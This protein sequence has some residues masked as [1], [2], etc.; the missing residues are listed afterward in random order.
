MGYHPHYPMD[1]GV[2]SGFSQSHHRLVH[3]L[4]V[5]LHNYDST[6][7][8]IAFAPQNLYTDILQS[9]LIRSTANTDAPFT[10]SDFT[11]FPNEHAMLDHINHPSYLSDPSV[12]RI[13]VAVVFES[14]VAPDITYRIR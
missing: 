9:Y 14:S 7:A 8:S 5:Q 6:H 12:P 10:E 1:L 11:S 3:D 2:S 4:A 13:A